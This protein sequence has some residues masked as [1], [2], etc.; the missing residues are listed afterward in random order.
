M[1]RS[2]V[3]LRESAGVVEDQYYL[4]SCSANAISNAYEMLVMQY[5][6]K[7]FIE[8]SRLF[9]YYNAR[10]I[11]GTVEEDTGT[12]ISDAL[13]GVKKF[14]LC[15][16]SLWP[17]DIEK[18][19]VVPP[20]ACYKDAVSRNI[21]NVKSIVDIEQTIETLNRNQPVVFGIVISNDFQ[22][23]SI[24]NPVIQMPTP[25][26]EKTGHAM[27]LVGYDLDKK[28]LLAKN[29]F[30][31]FWGDHGYCWIPFDYME[32]KGYDVWTFSLP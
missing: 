12:F 15:S 29:S 30:G 7:T 13:D 17:Y 5:R 28:L 3:D 20:D 4:G 2:K 18:F 14:G 23:T 24:T 32:E 25:N 19:N 10:L 22:Y 6:P 8:I 16:E 31:K 9:I 26:N 27:C 1:I 21:S 11:S